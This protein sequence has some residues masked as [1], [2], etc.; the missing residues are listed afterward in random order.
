M[1]MQ[2]IT[3]MPL[4]AADLT[5]NR[6]LSAAG[7]WL[8]AGLTLVLF[9]LPG[10]LFLSM[11]AFPVTV[12]MGVTGLGIVAG[13]FVGLRRSKRRERITVWTDQIEWQNTD[14]AGVSV[15]HRFNPHTVRLLLTRDE[16]EKTTAV[17]LRQGEET[18]ELGSF[19]SSEDK[20]SFA[21]ALGTALRQARSQPRG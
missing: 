7:A 6:S 10:L 11:G 17:R 15:M 20:S 21:K 9:A 2:A 5:P 19:L 4:F 1:P 14:S 12:L 3:T 18:V 13:L 16:H 8:L